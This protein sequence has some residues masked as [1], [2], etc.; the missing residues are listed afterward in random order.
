[1]KIAVSPPVDPPN[2]QPGFFTRSAMKPA[3]TDVAAD[4]KRSIYAADHTSG[5]NVYSLRNR[6]SAVE[7]LQAVELKLAH[8]EL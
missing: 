6:G 3:E 4:C 7:D 5:R 2:L 8:L 1:L